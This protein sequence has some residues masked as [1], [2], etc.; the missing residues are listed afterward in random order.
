MVARQSSIRSGLLPT[1]SGATGLTGAIELTGGWE[2]TASP[3]AG[4]WANTS[5]SGEWHP[6]V[7]P[8]EPAMQ[9]FDVQF[10]SE[11]AYRRDLGD[12]RGY[13]GGP[14]VVRFD[15]V[16]NAARVW[17]NGS[18]VGEH[19]GGFTRFEFDIADFLAKEGPNWLVVGVTDRSDSVSTAAHYAFHPIGGILRPVSLVVL[20]PVH[21]RRLHIATPIDD[22]ASGAVRLALDTEVAAADGVVVHLALRDHEGGAVAGW[23]D[24]T[25]TVGPGPSHWEFALRDVELWSD[26]RPTLYLLTATVLGAQTLEYVERV[27]FRSVR[28]EGNRLLVNDAEVVLRGINRHDLDPLLG[29]STDGSL[30]RRDLELFRDANINFV[31][32]S[33]YPPHPAL[34]EAADELGIFVEVEN[35]V[36]WAGQFGWPATQDEPR[37]GAEYL[38]PFAEMI[39]LH[40]NHPSVIIWSI[41]NE[42]TWGA[43]F[44]ASFD[45]ACELDPTRPVIMSFA[46]GPE[47]IVSSHY[48][49]YGA[50]LGSPGKPIL[51][52]EV[53]HL[54]VYQ[55][56]A[57]RRD[58]GVH[59]DWAATIDDFMSQLR[60]TEGAAGLALWSGV[61]EQFHLPGGTR[62]FGPWGIVDIWRR[63]K[64]EWWGVRAAFCPVR[65]VLEGAS[66]DGGTVSI[67]VRNTLSFFSLAEYRFDW[68]W[69]DGG[70][71]TVTALDVAPGEG[72]VLT[73]PAGSG[74]LALRV[75]APD[76]REIDSVTM[77]APAGRNDEVENHAG[78]VSASIREG[79]VVVESDDGSTVMRV[80]STTGLLIDAMVDGILVLGGPIEARLD[81]RFAG[82]WE[83]T[84]FSWLASEDRV[85]FVTT[86]R[87]GA[88]TVTLELTAR[89]DAIDVG[90]TIE[91]P[92]DA[93]S[94]RADEVGVV[95]HLSPEVTRSRWEA[96]SWPAV[97]ASEYLGRPAGTAVARATVDPRELGEGA[98]LWRDVESGAIDSS[99]L[100]RWSRDFRAGR[101]DIQAQSV[102]DDSGAGVEILARTRLHTRLSPQREV[103]EP[104]GQSVRLSGDWQLREA[105]GGLNQGGGG[106]VDLRTEEPGASVT[107]AFQG[108]S[109][110]ALGA[111]G[112]DLGI[113]S[114]ELDGVM[115]APAV[116]LFSPVDCP[117]HTFFSAGELSEGDHELCVTLTGQRHP[118]SLGTA[119]RVHSFEVFAGQPAVDLNVLSA[120]RYP[121]SGS[122]DWMDPQSVTLPPRIN[123][124]G[125]FEIQLIGPRRN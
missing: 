65:L 1:P 73:I 117:G 63:R 110:D 87:F 86:G 17:V 51:Q 53:V 67:P 75:V 11:V 4:F 38:G 76:G 24:Q 30:E 59:V 116:D 13:D 103:I 106:V 26:E 111:L 102:T 37:F 71:G 70:S 18:F 101:S 91:G 99:S 104:T 9:G 68:Q 94:G 72:G 14:V 33:H 21:L 45:L 115:V 47:H 107:V 92:A 58:P 118:W 10:D 54:P 64:P 97:S 122:F 50:D 12:V 5:Q 56:G 36:C 81:D 125:G 48:P 96:R 93:L 6:I 52:D 7:V 120:K 32:T 123:E 62:G 78:T 25:L 23:A 69:A 19:I 114:V 90:F 88:M 2:F 61:D 66:E 31:R 35:G 80:D 44:A 105:T 100:D 85:E 55:S 15:G 119:A 20:P 83:T 95:L 3:P 27:G 29:R 41:G 49:T 82:S 60:A 16:Y 112:P 40:R 46:G 113:V 79:Q 8:G 84:D 22:A 43:N 108:A 124:R 34:L 57:L 98:A 39:D 74:D 121:F 77:F 89:A 42:S 109:I 28:V